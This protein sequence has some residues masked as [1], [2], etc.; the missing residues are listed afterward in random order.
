MAE[1][2]DYAALIMIVI[3]NHDRTESECVISAPEQ[4]FV[5]D[6]TVMRGGTRDASV[7]P[8]Q[9]L[10][11][12]FGVSARRRRTISHSPQVDGAPAAEAAG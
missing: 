2:Y 6:M 10:T 5:R 3:S 4:L 12:I 7:V 9:A 11:N 8:A 1:G